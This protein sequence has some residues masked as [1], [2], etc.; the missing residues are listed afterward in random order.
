MVLLMLLAGLAGQPS[1]GATVRLFLSQDAFWS[2]CGPEASASEREDCADYIAGVVD[3]V[4]VYEVNHHVQPAMCVP[5]SVTTYDL[6]DA[7]A[8]RL[9][10]SPGD[11][12]YASASVIIRYIED[13]YPCQP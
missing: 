7:V 1:E 5:D 8:R 13:A 10:Q 2:M 6:R 12:Q 9:Q 11:L 4:R 3:T